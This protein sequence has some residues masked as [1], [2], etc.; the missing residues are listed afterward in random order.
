M[1]NLSSILKSEIARIA[2]RESRALTRV[3]NKASTRHRREIAALKRQVAA[4]ERHVA[5][6]GRQEKKRISAAPVP[7]K[8]EG[9]RFS[10]G[11]VAAHR[12]KL[13]L[14]AASYGRLVGV[15]GLTIYSWEGGKSKPREPQRVGWAA[16]RGMGKREAAE[17]L[18]MM[19][20]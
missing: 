17:R 16:V 20:A 11:W 2:R 10:S 12:K 5:F 15:S 14:S 4:L 3:T 8:A 13:G 1:P 7:S 9:V 19:G 6:L 18:E